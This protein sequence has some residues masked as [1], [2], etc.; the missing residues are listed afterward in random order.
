[1]DCK[2]KAAKI[3]QS[4]L[5]FILFVI[6][7]VI[8][9]FYL[10]EDAIKKSEKGATT[11]TSRRENSG[12]EYPAIIICPYPGFKPSLSK[13]LK[14]QANNLFSSKTPDKH[15]FDNKTVP[16]VFKEFTYGDSIKISMPENEKSQT[17][18]F[19]LL[20]EGET[21]FK[22]RNVTQTVELKTVQTAATGICYGIFS[23]MGRGILVE[24]KDPINS[25]DVPDRFTVYFLP[26]NEWQGAVTKNWRGKNIFEIDTSSYS[27]P[28]LL[29]IHS[30][31]NKFYPLDPSA[32]KDC[33]DTSGPVFQTGSLIDAN[34]IKKILYDKKCK[35]FCI[36]IQ[37]SLLFDLS[38]IKICS[39]YD[40]HHCAFPKIRSYIWKLQSENQLLCTKENVEKFYKGDKVFSEGIPYWITNNVTEERRN[41]ILFYMLW[42]FNSDHVTVQEEELIYGPKDL[43]SW[44]GGALGI[45]VGYSIFDLTSLLLDW[46]FQFVYQLI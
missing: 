5:N 22:I 45:F 33:I 44:I 31:M 42:N 9:Y 14:Y 43:L 40:D 11:I 35:E 19:I 6:L 30:T 32:S 13:K 10:M 1:M 15:L 16:Q 41:S 27:F 21:K 18:S 20:K 37:F 23:E 26:K 8:C 12:F 34:E 17:N 46:V 25:S 39:D 28:F 7:G 38:E 29:N 3:C 2:E 4:S 24:Y 36:P